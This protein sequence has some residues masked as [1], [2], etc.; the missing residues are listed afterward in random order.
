MWVGAFCTP[1][2]RAVQA[3]ACSPQL[4]MEGPSGVCSRAA[5]DRVLSYGPGV[6]R[7]LG[8]AQGRALTWHMRPWVCPQ[9]HRDTGGLKACCLSTLQR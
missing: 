9:H 6:A 8:G 5:V 1:G 7:G 4:G 3:G 2:S